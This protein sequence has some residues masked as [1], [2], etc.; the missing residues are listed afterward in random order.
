MGIERIGGPPFPW[1]TKMANRN[2][3]PF[4]FGGIMG[5]GAASVGTDGA[6]HVNCSGYN[7]VFERMYLEWAHCTSDRA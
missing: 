7:R 3:S 2:G 5:W 1:T 6:C 4:V